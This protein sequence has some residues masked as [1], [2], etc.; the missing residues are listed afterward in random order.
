MNESRTKRCCRNCVF[1]ERPTSR[2]L[3]I[4][5][6]RWP[7]L[8]LCFHCA[9]APGQMCE[10]MAEGQCPNFR[11]R[12]G[13]VVR[14][15][16]PEPPNDDIRYISLTQGKHA[17]V[18]AADYPELSRYRWCI[19]PTAGGGQAYAYRRHK[20]HPVYMHRQIMKPPPGMVVDHINGNSLDNRRCNLRIC[21]R[22]QNAQNRRWHGPRK[23]RFVGV[24]PVGDKWEAVV[25]YKGRKYQVGTFD[26][27]VEAAKARDA[28]KLEL[29]GEF[30]SLNFPPEDE[31]A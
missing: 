16:P 30:A 19:S 18:D 27:E 9:A 3:R 24:H 20:G 8:L 7:G 2:W 5:L 10:V 23:H 22:S 11:R 21:T 25:A 17:I 29:A 13:P 14:V 12:R 1:A 4:I 6:S 31:A 28:K 15:D 26:D